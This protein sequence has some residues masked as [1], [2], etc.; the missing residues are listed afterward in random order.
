[1][2]VAQDNVVEA[3]KTLDDAVSKIGIENIMIHALE[4]LKAACMSRNIPFNYK[5][6]EVNTAIIEVSFEILK[7]IPKYGLCYSKHRKMQMAMI[8]ISLSKHSFK[9]VI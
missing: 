5:I 9:F 6:P 3:V 4:T 1:M 7:L 2:L 8:R